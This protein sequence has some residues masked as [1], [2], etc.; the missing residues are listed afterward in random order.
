MVPSFANDD[1][2]P[3]LATSTQADKASFGFNVGYDAHGQLLHSSGLEFSYATGSDC[4]KPSKAQNCH[5]LTL[6]AGSIAWFVAQ[7]GNNSTGIFEGSGMLAVDGIQQPV[8]FWVT[9]VDGERLNATSPDHLQLQIFT[10]V[11][12]PAS[13]TPL[14]QINDD[15]LRGNIHIRA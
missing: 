3:G 13:D 11:Q 10:P 6:S 5:S 4:N 2:L 14:Y 15:V 12:N 8:N 9:G 7:G 1:R